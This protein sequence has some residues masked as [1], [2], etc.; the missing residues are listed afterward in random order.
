VDLYLR[1]GRPPLL[2]DPRAR[3]LFVKRQGLRVNVNASV[4]T[5]AVYTHVVPG[6][7]TKV[8]S[9]AHPRERLWNQRGKRAR[10]TSKEEAVR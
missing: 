7:L 6:E 10:A 2:K 9:K 5:T 1:E 8:V 4:Q 3:A